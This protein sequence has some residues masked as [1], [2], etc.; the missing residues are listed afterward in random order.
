MAINFCRHVYRPAIRCDSVSVDGYEVEN[1]VASD[2]RPFLAASFVKPPVNIYVSF[3]CSV[4][5]SH[6][7]IRSSH[8]AQR[9]VGFEIFTHSGRIASSW[10]LDDG[11]VTVPSHIPSSV[12]TCVGKAYQPDCTLFRFTNARYRTRSP[13]VGDP[14]DPGVP[15]THRHARSLSCVSDVCVRVVCAARA[16]VCAV[17]ALEIWGQPAF[18]CPPRVVTRLLRLRDH[19]PGGATATPITDST[20]SP[21]PIPDAADATVPSEFL[22][23]ITSE[24]MSLPM[25][26]PSGHCVDRSTVERHAREEQRW[27]RVPSDPFTGV[28]FSRDLAPVFNA[29]LK[30]R[31]DRF[32]LRSSG[33]DVD[34]PNGRTVG[35]PRRVPGGGTVSRLLLGHK[36]KV[37]SATSANST[38]GGVGTKRKLVDVSSIDASSLDGERTTGETSF[39][40]ERTNE[41]SDSFH[42]K[43]TCLESARMLRT[44]AVKTESVAR[45]PV[46]DHERNVSD[47]LK[48]A[49]AATLG[50]LP[51]FQRRNTQGVA[52][53][54]GTACQR[55]GATDATY[56][57][58]CDHAIC[59]T[60]LLLCS[61][62]KDTIECRQCHTNTLRHQIVR[63]HNQ[64]NDTK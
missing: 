27:G 15:L 20:V 61:N 52:A 1:L 11:D 6:I 21:V 19:P 13:W 64:A 23:V 44:D 12:F 24:L 51:S 18:A 40:E 55:C 14:V 45:T 10:L 50:R 33:E 34:L 54:T 22:D 3:P 2:R 43:R 41:L 39:C 30:A 56:R 7:E 42:N 5:V 36:V 62:S 57:L 46:S 48:V 25:T 26:L 28:T 59:R 53:V 4:D 58:S 38:T 29:P 47:C 35:G 37:E 31:I 8:G 16:G 9:S 63:I 60:C 32:L 17:G 49:L